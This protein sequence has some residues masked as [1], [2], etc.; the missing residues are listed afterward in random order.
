MQTPTGMERQKLQ[1]VAG[2]G[3]PGAPVLGVVGGDVSLRA[4]V[5]AT[6]Y[7]AGAERVVNA[8]ER[9]WGMRELTDGRIDGVVVLGGEPP[10]EV[11]EALRERVV[12]YRLGPDDRSTPVVT[13][14][15][16]APLELLAK[17]CVGSVRPRTEG[18]T[19]AGLGVVPLRLLG[20]L[21][22]LRPS[23]RIEF[24]ADG[25][26]AAVCAVGGFARAVGFEPLD[27]I[28]AL[29]EDPAIALLLAFHARERGRKPPLEDALAFVCEHSEVFSASEGYRRYAAHVTAWIT[30]HPLRQLRF[31][32]AHYPKHG[33]DLRDV[34]EDTLATLP[35]ERLDTLARGGGPAREPDDHD[36]R[37]AAALTAL[38]GPAWRDL[39]PPPLPRSPLPPRKVART[40]P[41]TGQRCHAVTTRGVG[42][43]ADSFGRIAGHPHQLLSALALARARMEAQGRVVPLPG[44]RFVPFGMD[45]GDLLLFYRVGRGPLGDTFIGALRGHHGVPIPVAV[46]QLG[47]PS[48]GYGAAEADTA[49][50][51]ITRARALRHANVVRIHEIRRVAGS[52]LVI[53]EL[54]HGM[55]VAELLR[56][57]ETMQEPLPKPLATWIAARVGMALEATARH[58]GP[59]GRAIL[60]AD[61][62]AR[63]ETVLVSFNGEVKLDVALALAYSLESD[64]ATHGQV[65]LLSDPS[66]ATALAERSRPGVLASEPT[67]WL[68]GAV[69]LALRLVQRNEA[70][71]L[72]LME[73]CAAHMLR[74]RMPVKTDPLRT[75]R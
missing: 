47:R 69:E 35:D 12:W 57:L 56:D 29:E 24:S 52:D 50:A 19:T 9:A 16:P 28:D 72:H 67:V 63:P 44:T 71:A 5:T 37:V 75:R 11:P 30:G 31:A 25:A 45:L 6:L 41:R 4:L 26:D 18:W 73:R 38:T 14:T 13:L 2:C 20:L 22:A 70:Y 32:H 39:E 49:L 23:L 33:L 10:H 27:R 7:L 64:R 59:T 17:A 21:A 54:V 62:D 60:L 8:A 68:A 3:E 40:R 43:E 65:E 48:N 46:R 34:L 74:L 58:R 15:W 66:L 1:P 36:A 55:S 42:L 51:E 53:M 61:G